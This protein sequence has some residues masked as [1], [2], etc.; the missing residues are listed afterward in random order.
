MNR[1]RISLYYLAGYLIVIGVALLLSPNVT[2][3]LMLSNSQY[4]DTFPR[5]AGML[6]SGLGMNIAGVI[7]ARAQALYPA[8]L[9]VRAF[10]LIG[11]AW[12]YV[13]TRDPFFL[14]LLAIVA[15]GMILTLLSY[16][17]DRSRMAAAAGE[18]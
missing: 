15:F 3:R 9:G 11:I 5:F 18:N 14:V 4:G 1:T 13:L 17:T 8:T 10:F 16:L 7:R 12:F 6:M 2:L